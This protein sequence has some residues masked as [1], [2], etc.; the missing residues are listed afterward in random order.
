MKEAIIYN[1]TST[2]E[3]N[4]ENQLDDCVKLINSLN[5]ID[6]QVLQEQQSAWKLEADADREVFRSIIKGI[7]Q[8]KV[9]TLI[10]WDLDRIYR[11]RKKLIAFFELC[12]LKDCKIYSFRQRWLEDLNKIPP[13]FNEIMSSLMLQIMGWLAEEES[14]KKSQRVRASMDKDSEGQTISKYGKVWGRKRL[15]QKT[16]D[17]IISLYIE[18]KK[19]REITG[20][21][22]YWDASGNKKNP[23]VGV[24]HKVIQEYRE[25]KS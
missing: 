2:E 7:E 25:K 19:I 13:P 5:I 6:Y 23:S 17:K 16:K 20:M 4:P 1:R 11:N 12:K 3:Q 24:V 18:G 15:S 8:K 14:L 9:K 22:H 10:V 21:A